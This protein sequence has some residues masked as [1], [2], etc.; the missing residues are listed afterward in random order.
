MTNIK[1]DDQ[2]KYIT[3]YS[4]QHTAGQDRMVLHEERI[5]SDTTN[6]VITISSVL[7]G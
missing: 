3:K 2:Y 1:G 4:N 5:V 6:E 7:T